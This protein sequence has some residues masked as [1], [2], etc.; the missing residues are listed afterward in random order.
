MIF[1]TIEI[2]SSFDEFTLKIKRSHDTIDQNKKGTRHVKHEEKP[3]KKIAFH[4]SFIEISGIL[5][6]E[7]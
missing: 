7:W 4:K 6:L 3:K 5:D 1:Y 2:C